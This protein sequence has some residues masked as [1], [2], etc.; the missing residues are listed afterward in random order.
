MKHYLI[1]GADQGVG[2]TY[3]I[4]ALLRALKAAGVSAAGF[5]PVTCGDRTE[6]REMRD[7]MQEPTLSLELLNPVYLRS[8]ADPQTAAMLERTAIE[9]DALVTAWQSLTQK[10]DIVLTEGCYGWLT[11]LAPGVTMQDFAQRLGV[12][13]LLV[14]ENRK[15]AA[16]LA[17]LT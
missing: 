11:P 7:A 5:K 16:S 13:V 6:V 12:P 15:G 1:A 10:Y 9:V 8:Q 14:L 17:A 3:V 2:K 4:C